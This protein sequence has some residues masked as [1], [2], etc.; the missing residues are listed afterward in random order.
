VREYGVAIESKVLAQNLYHVRIE[1][2]GYAGETKGDAY[3]RRISQ[4]LTQKK[5]MRI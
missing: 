1:T 2:R 4:P 5:E 3:K